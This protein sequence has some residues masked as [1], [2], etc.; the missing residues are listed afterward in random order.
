MVELLGAVVEPGHVAERV[1]RTGLEFVEQ[2]WHQIVDLAFHVRGRRGGDR[3]CG[4]RDRQDR[5]RNG[6]Q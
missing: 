2:R 1:D 6:T 5:T 3:R 4:Q